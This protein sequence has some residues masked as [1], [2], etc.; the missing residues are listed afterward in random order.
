LRVHQLARELGW[1]SKQTI[2]FLKARGEYVTAANS[3]V[4]DIV[5]REIRRELA[6]T[7]PRTGDV[8]DRL[9]P[10]LYGH[11]AMADEDADGGAAPW[12]AAVRRAQAESQR[13][14]G[15][16]ETGRHCP[17]SCRCCVVK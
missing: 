15:R 16:A 3:A 5:V 14:R 2:D 6:V 4:A 13:A 10:S 1:T 9:D 12:T 17:C 7:P 8:D 11:A